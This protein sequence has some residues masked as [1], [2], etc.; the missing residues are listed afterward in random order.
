V[1]VAV[2]EPVI[3]DIPPAVS[4]FCF[5]FV[6][7]CTLTPV[8]EVFCYNVIRA[9][10]LRPLPMAIVLTANTTAFLLVGSCMIA[11]IFFAK[12]IQ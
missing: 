12:S 1:E 3:G 8:F 11:P 6:S 4:H 9:K 7:V 5:W 2:Q 10:A